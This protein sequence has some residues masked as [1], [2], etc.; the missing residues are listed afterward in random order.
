MSFRTLVA[1]VSLGLM[2]PPVSAAPVDLRPRFAGPGESRVTMRIDQRYV[3]PGS[4]GMGDL[5]SDTRQLVVFREQVK[6]AEPGKG[7]EVELTYE[8]VAFAGQTQGGRVDFDSARDRGEQPDPSG[9][10]IDATPMAAKHLRELVGTTITLKFDAEGKITSV[11]GKGDEGIPMMMGPI[12]GLKPD[13]KSLSI[14]YSP[15]SSLPADK[16][17]AA[18]PGEA[19]NYDE[20]LDIEPM[21]AHIMKLKQGVTSADGSEAIFEYTGRFEQAEDANRKVSYM[22][23]ADSRIVGRAVWSVQG[24]FL[25]SAAT[26]VMTKVAT[27][28]GGGGGMTAT[29]TAQITIERERR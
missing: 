18:E 20:K 9:M 5:A 6:S 11:S 16:A 21:G 3:M 19:W 2:I 15:A 29:N 7:A 8:R 10:A 14:L 27:S 28:D 25:R 12:C 4:M 26:E 24:G 1:V 17:K 13:A 23:L 22:K